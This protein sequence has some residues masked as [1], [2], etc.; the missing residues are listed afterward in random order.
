VFDLGGGTFDISILEIG[1]NGVF[2]VIATA[3][4]TFLGGEDFDAPHHRL[5][6]R[7]LQGAARRRSPPRSHGPAAAQGRRREGQVRAVGRHRDRDQPAVH[8]LER[9]Q[10]GAAPA[11]QLTR[12]TLDQL[13]EDLVERCVEIC[14]Q[15]S[16]TRSSSKD[17]IE[18]VILVGGMTRMPAV[19]TR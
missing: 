18:E 16:R 13:C 7:G 15:T 11:A 17:E 3:G 1:S 9:A 12:A 10:R 14:R 2:K 8:H 5:A 19:Q 6:G 4:D